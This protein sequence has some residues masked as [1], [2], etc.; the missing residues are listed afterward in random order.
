MMLAAFPTE[1]PA[2]ATIRHHVAAG[3]EIHADEASSWNDLHGPDVAKR[4][5]RQLHG[6]L[7]GPG[8]GGIPL[9]VVAAAT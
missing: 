7:L 4:I 6:L 9:P 3:T 2:L 1:G 5:N 8:T